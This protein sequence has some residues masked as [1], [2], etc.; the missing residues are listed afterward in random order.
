MHGSLP[1]LSS[2]TVS[3]RAYCVWCKLQPAIV[4]AWPAVISFLLVQEAQPEV[5][6]N[7]FVHI[8]EDFECL[9]SDTPFKVTVV[10]KRRTGPVIECLI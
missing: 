8:L 1:I 4:S 5:K 7:I 3:G 9:E 10:C 2:C 6:L